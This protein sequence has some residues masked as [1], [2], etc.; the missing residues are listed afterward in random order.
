MLGG[1]SLIHVL[2]AGAS[3]PREC[4]FSMMVSSLTCLA[5]CCYFV[6]VCLSFSPYSIWS[7][8]CGLGFSQHG[9]L[10]VVGFL[11]WKLMVLRA[12]IP[13]ILSL[14]K[15]NFPHFILLWFLG[16]LVMAVQELIL[17]DSIYR[18]FL[19]QKFLYFYT[20][21]FYTKNF[22]I[23]RIFLYQSSNTKRIGL[24]YVASYFL[25]CIVRELLNLAKD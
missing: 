17:K 25:L 1:S 16:P 9:D 21:N 23:P 20:K 11:A 3:G 19:Y 14:L 7:S 5:P 4:I 8:Q 10:K 6:L 24:N 12:G 13:R 18:I 22:S 15:K 2:S